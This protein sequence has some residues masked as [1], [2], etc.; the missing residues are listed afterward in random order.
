[1]ATKTR[2][3][4]VAEARK[5]LD[6]EQAK[7]TGLQDRAESIRLALYPP[8]PAVERF[9]EVRAELEALG[10]RPDKDTD[11]DGHAEHVR[12]WRELEAEA[13][14]LRSRM[15][16]ERKQQARER[17]N[18]VRDQ[19]SALLAGAEP[20]D[21]PDYSRMA[22]DLAVVEAAV[23]MQVE[24]VQAARRALDGAEIEATE[25]AQREAAQ[26]MADGLAL[27]GRGV[28]ELWNVLAPL[29]AGRG[30]L[31]FPVDKYHGDQGDI[32]RLL[33]AIRDRYGVEPND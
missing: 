13:E 8:T 4:P 32:A 31:A 20:E 12:R 1:M 7:L 18:T 11:P 19:A 23:E 24:R 3:D 30:S 14:R 28:A 27:F 29:P 21:L 2:T 6:A 33:R 15:E 9:H 5:A 26:T 25:P 16:D 10:A 17:A 22:H